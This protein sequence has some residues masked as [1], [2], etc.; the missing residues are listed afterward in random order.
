MAADS[1]HHHRPGSFKQKNKTHKTGR[2]RSK[3]EID[4]EV[5]GRVGVKMITKK[6]K[7][8]LK[9][10]ARR[11]KAKQSMMKK[12]EEVIMKKRNIGSASG[13]PHLVVILPLSADVD[14]DK[15]RQQ[16]LSSDE[17]AVVSENNN[18]TNVVVPRFKTRISFLTPPSG[19]LTAILEAAKV[20]DTLLCVLSPDGGWDSFGDLCL[21]CIFAQGL[22]AT[23]HVVQGLD[24][25]PTKKQVEAKKNLQKIL[26]KRFPDKKLQT[27]DTNAEGMLVIR[28]ITNQKLREIKY[29]NHRSYLLARHVAFESNE[30][31]TVAGTLKVSGFIRGNGMSVNGL[32][33]L[34]GY[35]DFQ[36]SQ[37]DLPPDPCPLNPRVKKQKK[38]SM[39]T[40]DNGMDAMEEDIKLLGRAD[41][42]RQE[43]LQAEVIPDPMEGE[44]TWPTEEELAEA[45]ALQKAATEKKKIL[46]KV[47]KGTSEYQAAWI[48]DEDEREIDDDDDDDNMADH[49]STDDSDEDGSDDEEFAAMEQSDEEGEGSDGD[50]ADMETITVTEVDDDE[51]YDENLDLEEERTMLEKYRSER[52]H[53]MFPDEM[54][55]PMDVAARVRF[56][57]Y[58]GLKSF[59]T[60]PWD[61][62][63]NLP[64]DYARIFQFQNFKTTSKRVV[65]QEV[66]ETAMAGWYVTLHIVNVPKVFMENFDQEKP[67]VVFALLQYEQKMSV[68]H[69]AL[70]KY[71]SCRE[72]IKS[73][74]PLIFQVGCRRFSA[75]PI[76]SQHTVGNKH[77][78]ERY[79]RKDGITVASVYAP[80]TFP[81]AS[82]LVFKEN[83]DG[84]HTFVAVGTLLGVEP[85]RIVCKRV[86][87]S[88]HPYK[89]NKKK[90]VLRYMFFNREDILWF[91]PVELYTKWGRR[92]HIKEP[93]G[94][95]GH[96]KCVFDGQLKSQ[97]TVLMNLYKR[98]YPKWTYDPYAP[99]DLQVKIQTQDDEDDHSDSEMQ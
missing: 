20:A 47:P 48:V 13:A 44:Q 40:D 2:H 16:L 4:R 71:H 39:Q 60:S 32:V 46:K 70:K 72:P 86:V 77:K 75:G 35:G 29:R 78:N 94:T 76:F 5:K 99:S 34:P 37:I 57:K 96:M 1:D 93:I 30:D 43:S 95:H 63:E 17:S 6:M 51:K 58:R 65:N 90:S 55:T 66:E 7:R 3:G 98:V 18:I 83:L 56:Q 74:E 81:P 79:L 62:K 67:L 24:E 88:G 27:L 69:F 23:V 85:N 87:L 50:R 19:N 68:L 45:E 11:N 31:S 8:E 97:D 15:V 41:P 22:P 9:K 28:Q 26:E 59:R 84:S 64:T 14:P 80:I 33:H 49:D 61:P 10:A 53:V 25:L 38:D 12:R 42:A 82:V 36:L 89:I 52:Q 92:G 54:D 21:T 91:K 73:K